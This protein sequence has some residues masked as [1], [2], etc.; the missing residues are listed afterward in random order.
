MTTYLEEEEE[1]CPLIT[2]YTRKLGL[3]DK[4]MELLYRV[5]EHDPEEGPIPV[6][7]PPQIRTITKAGKPFAP[8]NYQTQSIAHMIKMHRYMD[9]H[10]VGLGK[11]ICAI[12]ASAYLMNKKP[13]MKVIVLGTKSTTY[14]WKTEYENFSTLNA[15]VLQD[16][17]EGLK[18]SEARL[19][20]IEDFMVSKD[21][22]VLIA[23]YTSLVGRRRTLEGEFDADGNPISEGQKEE[24]SPEVLLLEAIM[25]KHGHNVILILDE[26]QKFKSTTSQN[27]RMLLKIQPHIAVIWAMTATIIQNS[28]DEFYSI[29]VAIGVR[30]FGPMKQFRENFCKYKM[31]HVG[32][33]K[34]M[35]QLIGYKNVKL[36]KTEMRPFYYG[37]SQAQVKEPLPKLSTQYHPVDLDKIQTKML[38][39]IKAKKFVLP[40]IM[41]KNAEGEIYEKE[42]DPD[43]MMTMLA[44]T[45]MI[46]N[47]PN[48]LFK[49]EPTKFFSKT[50]S[51]KE[52]DLLELLDGELAGEKVIVFTKFRT[53]IDRFEGLSKA[54]HYGDRK[55]L[56]ITGA[57]SEKQR[58]ENKQKFQNDPDYNLLFINTAAAE[59]VNLQQAAHMVLLDVPWSWGVLIQLVGRMVRMASPHSACT[60]H[61]LPA[62]GTIDEYAIDTL[63]GKGELFE[64]ILGE[65]Y[66][67][68]LLNDSNDLDLAAGM[69]KINDDAEFRKLLK[70][71]VKVMKMGAFIDGSQ[72]KE[73]ANDKD[74]KMAFEVGAEKKEKKKV[75]VSDADLGK[76]D[77]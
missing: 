46:A 74:Y 8:R 5:R 59:G 33:G 35:P 39:D 1:P 52:D 10:A 62:K 48:L 47:N 42:R 7:I 4:T 23:K 50:L 15:Q 68:G 31:V 22:D 60:L 21:R 51:P 32:K 66:S 41:K 45:Q 44:V 49:D 16:K 26:C 28:L 11:T 54:G 57:E 43:N 71:H 37:R 2:D 69:D 73:A 36:F 17:Y 58:E 6:T 77:F 67:S 72:V 34:H 14:Q 65:S 56:R 63:K 24:Y 29:S 3:A 61:I 53:W 25:K 20:Q 40:P 75:S 19:K 12:T 13:G 30:P 38:E 27:R 9:G 55:F 18:G 70:A 64:I 76:W